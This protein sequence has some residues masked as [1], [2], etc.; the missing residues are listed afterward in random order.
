MN[1][2]ILV[3]DEELS[4]IEKVQCEFDPWIEEGLF[5]VK[6]LLPIPSKVEMIDRIIEEKPDAIIVD[7][8]LNRVKKDI[9]NIQINYNGAALILEFLNKRTGFPCFIASSYENDAVDDKKT[10][11][12][13]IIYSKSEL[14]NPTSKQIR[15]RERVKKQ[16]IKY[17]R[18]VKEKQERLDS[19]I[20]KR[21]NAPLSLKEEE[22]LIELD[23]YLEHTLNKENAV[24]KEL[25]RISNQD[26]LKELIMLTQEFMEILKNGK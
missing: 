20:E 19:L 13:N 2:K 6:P 26:K 18:I 5:E 11:D 7:Y 23:T 17:N 14:N 21:R 9:G 12:V 8:Q 25:K 22:E 10:M 16:I 4:E 1:F 24:P 3:I 15:F